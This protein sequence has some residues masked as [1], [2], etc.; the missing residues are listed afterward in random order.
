MEK[1]GIRTYCAPPAQGS[2]QSSGIR[3]RRHY[4]VSPA[5]STVLG[6][7]W[8]ARRSGCRA[9]AKSVNRHFGCW[10]C[11]RRGFPPSMRNPRVTLRSRATNGPGGWLNNRRSREEGLF[12]FLLLEA[13]LPRFL[14]PLRQLIAYASG[15]LMASTRPRANSVVMVRWN[16]PET[17]KLATRTSAGKLGATKWGGDGPRVGPG[18]PWLPQCHLQCGAGTGS[19]LGHQRDRA[20]KGWDQNLWLGARQVRADRVGPV[21]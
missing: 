14:C 1:R 4:L 8:L 21:P 13:K 16:V 2:P 20:F 6:G 7:L 11:D 5:L 15:Q 3:P 18:Q 10:L 9:N 17:T 12:P 19:Q